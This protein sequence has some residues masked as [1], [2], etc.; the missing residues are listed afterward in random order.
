M[1]MRYVKLGRTGLD[2]SAVI[3]GCMS[4]GDPE[5]RRPPVDPRRGRGR[6]FIRRRARGG[7]HDLRHRQRLL[8]RVERGDHRP[9]AARLRP[10]RGRRDRDQGARPDAARARTA[11]GSSRKAILHEIDAACAGSAPT[12]STS[13]RSTAGTRRC[14]S[15]RRWRRCTTS[16]GRARRA[17][18]APRRCGPGSS[19]K[20]Q[21]VAD[22][23]RLDAVR[24]RCRTTTTCSTA[25]RSGRCSR[26]ASTRAS[27]S[28]R[29]AR[30]PA[31]G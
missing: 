30:S 28:S 13:T 26:S 11:P 24:R 25:R 6:A 21:H 5:P 4:Y 16:C 12:T 3:L 19:R 17:T 14:R 8:R 20:A 23:Q 9:R 7:H 29:G 15:R 1:P 22:A 18:S 10:P 2:V 27:A 31:A